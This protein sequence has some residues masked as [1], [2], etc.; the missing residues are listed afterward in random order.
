VAAGWERT[1]AI[2]A[3]GLS[4]VIAIPVILVAGL[5][6]LV[7]SM[8][9]DG[10]EVELGP[11]AAG[12]STTPDGAVQIH[13]GPC[14][15]D[16]PFQSVR[17]RAADGTV[18]WQAEGT[19]GADQNPATP[20]AFD[21]LVVGQ[22]PSGFGDV[23]PLAAPLDPAATYTAELSLIGDMTA[24]SIAGTP[25]TGSSAP[26][27]GTDGAPGTGPSTADD[28]YT[29]LGQTATFRPSDLSPD[30]ITYAGVAIDPREFARLPCHG[31][32]ES[33]LQRD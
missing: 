2:V 20:P 25:G 14:G 11:T 22:A 16:V 9:L 8:S 4:A 7:S 15:P 21:T 19:A 29:A 30:A 5:F 24:S 10:C 17:V 28:M 31:E 32:S 6:L 23:V 18:V 27:G 26:P 13:A 12:V 1:V 3:A 33:E